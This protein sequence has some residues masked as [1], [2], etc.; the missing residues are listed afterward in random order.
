MPSRAA[1]SKHDR[2]FSL[3]TLMK[4][5]TVF[6]VVLA[7]PQGYVLLVI[8]TA[9]M[10]LGWAILWFLIAFQTPIYRLLSGVK[11]SRQD[12]TK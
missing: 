12:D 2:Q 7:F 1:N 8:G 4:V 6:C 9:W 10:L 11:R 5:V 3:W